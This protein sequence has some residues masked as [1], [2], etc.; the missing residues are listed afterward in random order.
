MDFLNYQGILLTDK[1]KR[2]TYVPDYGPDSPLFYVS[3][4]SVVKYNKSKSS[5]SSKSSS[6]YFKSSK[7]EFNEG[8][9]SIQ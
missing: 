1:D 9:S 7:S 6:A 2:Q 5:S 8:T 3:I 4:G